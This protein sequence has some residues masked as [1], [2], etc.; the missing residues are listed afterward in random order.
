MARSASPFAAIQDHVLLPFASRLEDADRACRALLAGDVIAQAVGRI[1]D[2]WLGDEEAFPDA[3]S[4]RQAYRAFLE[5][6][7]AASQVFTE[8]AVRAR[9]L[10][11]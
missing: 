2:A 11:V 6:R 3:A 9:S 10:R 4:H 5:A 8:E 1:P 7:A